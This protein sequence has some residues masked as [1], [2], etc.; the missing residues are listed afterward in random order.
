MFELR[1]QDRETWYRVFYIKLSGVVY[2]LH[3]FTK[4]TNRTSN[5]DIEMGRKRLSDLKQRLA[6]QKK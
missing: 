3:C 5:A 4:K 1:E 6:E 2:V